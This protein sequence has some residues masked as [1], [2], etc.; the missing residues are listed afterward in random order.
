[1]FVCL[2]VYLRIWSL[3]LFYFTLLFFVLCLIFVK[4][5][6][7]YLCHIISLKNQCNNSKEIRM[8]MLQK[9]SVIIQILFL[10]SSFGSSIQL[11]WRWCKMKQQFKKKLIFRCWDYD[12]TT[13][14]RVWEGHGC[15]IPYMFICIYITNYFIIFVMFYF[16]FYKILVLKYFETKFYLVKY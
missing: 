9:L 12:I 1:M 11:S 5:W 16:Y 14:E 13:I 2:I 3:N 8:I 6:N 7:F 15:S 10:F 4:R